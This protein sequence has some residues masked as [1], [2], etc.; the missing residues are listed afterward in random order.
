MN[1]VMQTR[2]AHFYCKA[3]FMKI[4]WRN[5]VAAHN[6]IPELQTNG[7]GFYSFI[8]RKYS[9]LT[10]VGKSTAPN[11]FVPDISLSSAPPL[12]WGSNA[13]CNRGYAK[14]QNKVKRDKSSKAKKGTQGTTSS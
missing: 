7:P 13:I 2:M 14:G 10:L 1:F 12:F 3:K 4:S 5:I 9:V 6:L 8:A 11:S